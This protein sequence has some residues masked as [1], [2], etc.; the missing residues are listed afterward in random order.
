MDHIDKIGLLVDVPNIG[1]AKI[2]YIGP[3]ETKNGTFV[4]VDLLSGVG[5]NDGSFKGKRYFETRS[6]Q[7]GL[8]IQWEKVAGL[9]P[10]TDSDG[11]DRFP[12]SPTPVR[13]RK[14]D[15]QLELSLPNS[16]V[17]D[18]E[19]SND[20][21]NI[22]EAELF[23]YKRMVDD[24]RIV[25]EEIQLAIDEY[26]TKLESI[27]RERNGLQQQLD[28]ERLAH[29]RQKQF[30]ENEHEQL[31]SVIDELQHE[32]NRN[33][34]ILADLLKN[35]KEVIKKSE[36]SLLGANQNGEATVGHQDDT[37][38]KSLKEQIAELQHYRN[39]QEISKLA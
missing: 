23:Q 22:Y 7:S 28:H 24:Q 6:G 39:Q 29:E 31:L 9:L 33:T 3:V 26:E 32:I 1:K 38:L 2:K 5:K 10:K 16:L 14:A 21:G 30:Y 27:E 34:S 25:L 13:D 36:G 20:S 12:N 37:L 15:A 4:G 11:I 8:F 17:L 19:R 35:D 18:G